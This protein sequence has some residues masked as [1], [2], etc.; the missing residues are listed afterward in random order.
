MP[1][2]LR[3]SVGKGKHTHEKPFHGKEHLQG[4]S[5]EARAGIVEAM[6]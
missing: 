6:N 4:A 2:P 3:H 1:V 5:H